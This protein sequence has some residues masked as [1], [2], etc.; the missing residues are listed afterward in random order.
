M[1]N[2]RTLTTSSRESRRMRGWTTGF[3]ERSAV[4]ATAAPRTVKTRRPPCGM[5]S[6]AT[7]R[8][9]SRKVMRKAASEVR[10]RSGP[11]PDHVGVGHHQ[12]DH[13]RGEGH[14]HHRRPEVAAEQGRERPGERH[15]R[16]GPGA[17]QERFGRLVVGRRLLALQADEQAGHDGQAEREE[18]FVGVH[19][20]PGSILHRGRR[21]TPRGRPG[22]V[23]PG[24][25]D[26]KRRAPAGSDPPA[27]LCP[28]R[29]ATA[30]RRWRPS[31]SLPS[32]RTRA[33]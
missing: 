6:W 31:R 14:H 11:A 4:T 22:R 1:R 10:P 20:A 12:E 16:I 3:E 17:P 7:E 24:W 29:F 21:E 27:P 5:M 32:R 23:R 2:L 26:G 25:D 28:R 9:P 13:H 19:G 18:G 8:A 33:A 30:P 15:Q